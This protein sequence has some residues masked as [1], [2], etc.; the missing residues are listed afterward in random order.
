MPLHHHLMPQFAKHP[1]RI[2]ASAAGERHWRGPTCPTHP[3]ALRFVSSGQCTACGRERSRAQSRAR[4]ADPLFIAA[5]EAQRLARRTARH[6]RLLA[7]RLAESVAQ[8]RP[9][10]RDDPKRL[11]ALAAGETTW[12]GKR[13]RHGHDGRRY[14]L[15][16]SCVE[17]ARLHNEASRAKAG[18]TGKSSSASHTTRLGRDALGRRR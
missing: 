2:A 8:S 13:C 15:T 12:Q 11:A 17:C 9:P 16:L 7:R 3:D 1:A 4:N 10:I 5:R 14:A 18:K 6:A